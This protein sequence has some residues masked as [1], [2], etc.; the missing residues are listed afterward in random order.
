MIKVSDKIVEAA[1]KVTFLLMDCDGV[2][3]DGR[4]Y[5]S[6]LGEEIKVFHVRDGQ[7]L[8]SWHQAGFRSGIITGRKSEMLEVRARE[9]G[10]HHLIQDS[11]EKVK[12][13][14]EIMSS[15]NLNFEE[16]AYIGDDIGDLGIL[17]LVGFPV[18]VAD[19]APELNVPGAYKTHQNG[20]CGAVREVSDLLL[21]LKN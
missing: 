5:Y 7:G 9:L 18:V 4:L 8:V 11:S 6:S 10:I 15:E 16:I 3:T 20:G 14:E 21:N 2:L 13:L 17:N 19:C 12:D 1:K